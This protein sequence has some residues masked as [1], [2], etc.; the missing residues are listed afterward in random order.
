VVYNPWSVV[1]FLAAPD[2]GCRPY[3][4]RTSSNDLLYRLLTAGGLGEPGDLEVLLSGGEV[5]RTIEE[6]VVFHDLDRRPDAVWSLLLFSGYLKATD[7]RLEDGRDRA[8]LSIPNREVRTVWE[9]VFRDW[10]QAGLG[11]DA[12]IREL[13]AALLA[14]DA[15]TF[16][17]LLSDLLRTAM[18]FH[19]FGGPRPERVYHAFIA[20]LL[21][22]LASDYEVRSNRESGY[23]RYDVMVLPRRPG[24]AGVVVELKVL[25]EGETVEGS[26]EAALRQ[27]RERDYATELRAR[28]ADPVRELAVVFDGKRA[29]AE[30]VSEERFLA[31]AGCGREP[32]ERRDVARRHDRHVYGDGG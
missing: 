29:W 18:S 24:R 17:R 30:A 19:D 5:E 32:D 12:A 8:G 2:A 28:G 11:T 3:W 25:D 26:L 22:Q 23:G 9:T 10:L 31:A 4:S 14:G 16:G 1:S 15:G 27:V 21:V 7:A 13:L 6:N 20:G